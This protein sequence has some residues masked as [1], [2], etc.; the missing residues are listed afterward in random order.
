[1]NV[2]FLS[3]CYM[4]IIFRQVINLKSNT[5]KKFLS[6]LAVAMLLVAC[7]QQQKKA[8]PTVEQKAV[9]YAKQLIE[10]AENE[11]EAAL[12]ALAEEIDAWYESL[13]EEDKAKA[14][15]AVAAYEEEALASLEEEEEEYYDEYEVEEFECGGDDDSWGE[16]TIGE[17]ADYHAL[18]IL[19]ATDNDDDAAVQEA[20][21]EMERWYS[22][23]D[24]RDKAVANAVLAEYDL[25]FEQ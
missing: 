21:A 5:M 20:V 14:D 9:E 6:I 12:L 25:E 2:K 24:E 4:Y 19:E 13:S 16:P 8:E 22:E 11:D 18:T 3:L 1:M 7:G 15:E 17:M 10:I 23:L